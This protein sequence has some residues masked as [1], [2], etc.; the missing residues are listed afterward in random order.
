[1]DLYM[2]LYAVAAGDSD[3]NARALDRR[4]EVIMREGRCVMKEL[5]EACGGRVVEMEC[6]R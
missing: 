2:Y 6:V 3:G 4:R 5:F 1:M